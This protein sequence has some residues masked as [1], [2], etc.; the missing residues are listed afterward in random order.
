VA[1]ELD[2]GGGRLEDTGSNE[3]VVGVT[4]GSDPGLAFVRADL[5]ALGTAGGVL[6]SCCEP[7][8]GSTAV[9]VNAQRVGDGALDELPLDA[10]NATC[11]DAA[12]EFGPG[13]GSHVEVVLVSTG[14]VGDLFGN[15][16]VDVHSFDRV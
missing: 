16:S 7:V 9:H 1:G 2:P 3:E 5:Q 12:G 15:E 11:G 4:L 6:N 14:L 13:G 8:L 10:V